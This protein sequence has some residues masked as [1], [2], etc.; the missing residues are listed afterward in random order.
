[1]CVCEEGFAGGRYPGGS[2][3]D[4]QAQARGEVHKG[5]EQPLLIPSIW[6]GYRA[7]ATRR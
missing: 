3:P 1:M 7:P 6:E 5:S 4:E 2:I